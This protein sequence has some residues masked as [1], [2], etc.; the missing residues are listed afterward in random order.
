ML[1]TILEM[2]ADW[3]G[4]I[5]GLSYVALCLFVSCLGHQAIAVIVEET[6]LVIV[7]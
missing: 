3:M 1:K 7:R 6:L 2:T 4:G 5:L